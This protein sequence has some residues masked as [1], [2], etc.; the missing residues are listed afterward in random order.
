MPKKQYYT[1]PAGEQVPA[2]YVKPY[3]RERDRIAQRILKL[4]S[5]EQARLAKVK[6]DTI[7]LIHKL[8]DKAASDADVSLGGAKGNVQFRSFDGNITIGVDRNYRTEFDERLQLAQQLITEAVAEMTDRVDDADLS[9]IAR[10]AFQ[11]RKSG[12]LDMQRIRD[13]RTYN[14]SHPKWKKACEIISE[15]ER[16]IGHRDYIRVSD[17]GNNIHLDISKV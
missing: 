10:R 9:E 3:D 16:T 11:P 5:E 13:L 8:M 2:K 1:D 15:C 14:V 7:D 4:W 12:N 17:N 6:A